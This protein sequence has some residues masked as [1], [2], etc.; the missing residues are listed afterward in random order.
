MHTAEIKR[1]L[2]E[3]GLNT[4][5]FSTIM[6]CIFPVV[7]DNILIGITFQTRFFYCFFH[8]RKKN[9]KKKRGRNVKKASYFF[10]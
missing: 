10:F 5:L 6:H 8:F 9:K 2:R 1:V 3:I 7:S 4:V